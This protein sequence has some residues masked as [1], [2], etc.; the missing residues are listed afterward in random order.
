LSLMD[1]NDPAVCLVF[2]SDP[3]VPYAPAAAIK[4]K[5][6]ASHGAPEPQRGEIGVYEVV[7]E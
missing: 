1:T 5:L 7:Y 2:I 4:N 3:L 6:F